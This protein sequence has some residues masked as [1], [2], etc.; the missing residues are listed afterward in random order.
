MKKLRET[1]RHDSYVHTGDPNPEQP[2]TEEPNKPGQHAPITNDPQLY[3]Q[4]RGQQLPTR[5]EP[6][7]DKQKEEEQRKTGTR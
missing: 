3:E 7:L 1:D 6:E 2:D 4:K 5:K